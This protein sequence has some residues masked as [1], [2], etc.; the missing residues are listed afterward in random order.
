[1][2]PRKLR[3]DVFVIHTDLQ[4]GRPHLGTLVNE[5]P[6]G[7]AASAERITAVA[8]LLWYARQIDKIA[9]VGPSRPVWWR[10]CCS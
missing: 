2:H 9:R 4:T 5:G 6:F 7:S 10:V 1:V 8:T 3:A